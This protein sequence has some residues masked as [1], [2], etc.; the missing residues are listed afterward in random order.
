[1]RQSGKQSGG[2]D[3]KPVI[4]V[5]Q[6][7]LNGSTHDPRQGC[8]AVRWALLDAVRQ[9]S[10]SPRLPA[11]RARRYSPVGR[12]ASWMSAASRGVGRNEGKVGR[13]PLT[14]SPR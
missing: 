14:D 3:V 12:S 8:T 9:A 5:R 10:I 13:V 2:V 7:N 1:M 11:G 6:R 4:T